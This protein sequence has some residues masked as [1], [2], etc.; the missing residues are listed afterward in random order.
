MALK[1]LIPNRT[2]VHVQIC[3]DNRTVVAYINHLGGTRSLELNSIAVK[4]LAWCLE[5]N[6][7]LSALYVPQI[8]NKTAGLLFRLKLES[9][10]WM[11][12]LRIFKQIMYVYRMPVLDLFASTLSHQVPKYFSWDSGS[13]SCGNGCILR[14]LEQRSSLYVSSL[15]SNSKMSSENNRTQGNCSFDNTSMAVKTMVSH[16][17]KSPI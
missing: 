8:M 11:L 14:K 15:Q 17:T 7:F 12:S 9:I 1:F 4:M 2:N 6:T 3:I 13:T 16:A 10:E 5:R